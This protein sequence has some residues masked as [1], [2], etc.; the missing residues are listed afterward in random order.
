[1]CFIIL[2]K[3]ARMDYLCN[4]A[5]LDKEPL[6][7]R[8]EKMALKFAKKILKHPEHKQIFKFKNDFTRS[9]KTVLV[10]KYVTAR[11]RDSAV[12]SLS[13]L[14]NEKLAHRL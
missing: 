9:G 5:I 12:P 2:G 6:D 3:H 1:M 7:V 14:I 10:P 8:R 4:L 13:K 11:Y